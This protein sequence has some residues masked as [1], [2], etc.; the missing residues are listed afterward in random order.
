MWCIV[1]VAKK[2]YNIS[3]QGDKPKRNEFSNDTMLA[4]RARKIYSEGEEKRNESKLK[5]TKA[6]IKTRI[7][8]L[9]FT[10]DDQRN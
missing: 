7:F 8:H 4:F 2:N 5:T 10:T 3:Q 6:R 9:P 1:V